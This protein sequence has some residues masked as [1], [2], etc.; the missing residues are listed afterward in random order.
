ML[1]LYKSKTSILLQRAFLKTFAEVLC[2]SLVATLKHY[3]AASPTIIVTK[4][5]A[6]SLRLKVSLILAVVTAATFAL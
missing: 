1:V 6:L 2:K 4:F 5:S 3:F